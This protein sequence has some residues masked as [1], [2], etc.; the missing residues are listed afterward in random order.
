[1]EVFRRWS[2]EDE[3]WE[4]RGKDTGAW[5]TGEPRY[6]PTAVQIGVIGVTRLY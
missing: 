4:G 2:A 3:R 6:L 5:I 1:M